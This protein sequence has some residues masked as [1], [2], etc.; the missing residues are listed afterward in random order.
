MAN[1]DDFKK[2]S[3]DNQ[4]DVFLELAILLH[5]AN[6]VSRTF[7]QT[8]ICEYLE[9]NRAD[10]PTLNH[11]RAKFDGLCE[12]ICNFVIMEDLL[13]KPMSGP[14][15]L[16]K[17][18]FECKQIDHNILLKKKNPFKEQI[19]LFALNNPLIKNSHILNVSTLVELVIAYVFN[20][21]PYDIFN[22][23]APVTLDNKVN[24]EFVERRLAEL[25]DN[26]YVKFC[27]FNKPSLFKFYGHSM[28]IKKT[29]DNK[30]SF[31]D[32][33]VGE[34]KDL[35]PQALFDKIDAA[36]TIYEGTGM[37]FLDGNAYI[38]HLK[39]EKGL[40]ESCIINGDARTVL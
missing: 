40:S 33:N 18:K 31:F 13:G 35:S 5:D 37:A 24:R 11:I 16:R 17:E 9:R 30:Y 29:G 27:V 32:P 20:K 22:W 21:F 15:D 7:N 23:L 19:K 39:E 14:L 25:P 8:E 3:S 36:M 4:D 2:V 38:N 10:F 34:D 6:T 1:P 12:I 28:L 26:A